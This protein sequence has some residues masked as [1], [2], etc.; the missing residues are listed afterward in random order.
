MKTYI[1]NEKYSIYATVLL[2]EALPHWRCVRPVLGR[3]PSV[4]VAGCLCLCD[5]KLR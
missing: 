2:V 4:R 1:K 5:E 3:R